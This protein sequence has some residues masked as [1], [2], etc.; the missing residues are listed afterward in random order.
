M[1]AVPKA[2]PK[3]AA[4]AT[5]V[6]RRSITELCTLD[7]HGDAGPL[8]KWLGNKTPRDFLSGLGREEKFWVVA[9]EN[10]Q[11]SGGGIT[12]RRGG[13][14]GGYRAPEGPGRRSGKTCQ[15]RH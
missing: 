6:L 2:E 3:D 15:Q 8:A 4:A 11:K 7:H 13:T 9:G 10:E 1:V 14:R 12:C 5:E